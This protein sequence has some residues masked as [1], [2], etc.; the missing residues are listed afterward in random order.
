MVSVDAQM[1][2]MGREQCSVGLADS[3]PVS[4]KKMMFRTQLQK[5]Q[6]TMGLK[7]LRGKI[8]R[9]GRN[10][11]EGRRVFTIWG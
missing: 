6:E 10:H 7:I 4:R 1:N 3:I 11:G 9:R 2:C 5:V 8:P